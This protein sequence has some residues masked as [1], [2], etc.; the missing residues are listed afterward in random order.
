MTPAP[1]QSLP[2]K[3][4]IAALLAVM[5]VFY[6]WTAGSAEFSLR[7]AK[8]LSGYYNLLADAFL[9]G[10]LSLRVQPTP[11]LLALPDP[12]DPV[13]N[14]P[15]R[16]HDAALFEGKYY[17]YYGPAPALVV[18]APFRALTGLDLPQSLGA[19]AA[20]WTGL[21]CSFLLLRFF[22]RLG[23]SET[24][25]WLLAAAVPALAFGNIVPFLL[26][27]PSHYEVAIAFGYALVFASLYCFATGSLG[28]RVSLRRLALASVLLGLAV[29][30]RFPMLAAALAPFI[31]YAYL[32]RRS[33]G[34]AARRR[35]ALALAMLG[36]LAV[37]LFLLGLYNYERFGS[38]T[39]FGLR[40]TLQGIVS[41]RQYTFVSMERIPTSFFY[42]VLVPPRFAA[43]FPFVTLEP[44]AYLA[45]PPGY[46]LERV[47]G[48]LPMV[49]LLSVL[50]VL[51]V[52][53]RRLWLGQRALPVAIGASIAIGCA[54]LGLYCLSGG[55]MRYEVDFA[56]FLL[57]PALLLWFAVLRTAG[58][59][60]RRVLATAFVLLL[61]ATVSFNGA[62]SL[63]GYYNNLERANSKVYERLWR[64]FRPLERALGAR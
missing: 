53:L 33:D 31:L 5:A 28:A 8:S 59:R 62:I 15:Y 25:S 24:P 29:G 18:F 58:R 36:P 30:S 46:V 27:R 49:P 4:V 11:E 41:A 22:V 57:L 20:C 42:Y 17:L 32:R 10:Q 13:Q 56:T 61:A 60:A 44:Q 54:L 3:A 21:V 34:R 51:P 23:L 37:C 40:H 1:P 63:T 26:R 35:L 50:L 19:A 6:A 38:W 16:L 43:E 64:V 39:D 45:P 52:M 12:Y 14:Q 47:A 7:P 2:Q 9:A 55:T 48:I